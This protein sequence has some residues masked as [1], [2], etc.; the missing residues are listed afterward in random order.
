MKEVLNLKKGDKLIKKDECAEK[1]ELNLK[2]SDKLLRKDK[3]KNLRIKIS[4]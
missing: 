3:Y 2:E 4:P 1:A